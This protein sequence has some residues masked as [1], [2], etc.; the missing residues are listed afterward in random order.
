VHISRKAATIASGACLA[1]IIA[2]T[3]NQ[4]LAHAWG[5][6]VLGSAAAAGAT[7]L[8]ARRIIRSHPDFAQLDDE[9]HRRLVRWIGVG[10]AAHVAWIALY[11]INPDLALVWL[12]A[13]AG[14][15]LVEYVGARG[16]EYLMAHPVRQNLPAIHE[17]EIVTESISTADDP[18]ADEAVKS[19]AS[20]LA[21]AGYPILQVLE[22][23]TFRDGVGRRFT[24]RKPSLAAVAETK[25][26]KSNAATDFGVA[27]AEN[28]AIALSEATGRKI[29]TDWV[30][31]TKQDYAGYYTISVVT[32]DVMAEVV[33]YRFD[34]T[35]R[36]IRELVFVGIQ[37]DGEEKYLDVRQHGQIV[38]KTRE[39]KTSLVHVLLTAMFQSV[40]AVV[41]VCGVLKLYD[42]LA[43][44]LAGY[45]GEDVEIPFD[46]IASGQLHTM[47]MLVGA[48]A[49]A[50]YRQALP[51]DERGGLPSLFVFLDEAPHVLRN[52]SI[53]VEWQGVEYTAAQLVALIG[54][55]TGS[56]DVWEVVIAQRGTNDM[57]G[58]EGGDTKANFGYS[59]VFKSKDK[60][61]LGRTLGDE[62]YKLPMPRHKGENWMD[63]G[64]GDG[65]THLR[66]PYI[67]EVD[68]SKPR[69]HDGMT[70]VDIAR[71]LFGS[72]TRLDPGTENAVAEAIGDVFRN[73]HRYA[74]QGLADYLNGAPTPQESTATTRGR[75]DARAALEA[76]FGSPAELLASAPAPAVRAVPEPTDRRDLVLAILGQVVE[77]TFGESGTVA[78]GDIIKALREMGDDAPNEN[79]VTNLLGK[80]VREGV[81]ERPVKGRYCLPRRHVA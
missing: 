60:A 56:A 51:L 45:E 15:G 44:W 64:D 63:A 21:A 30:T 27:S 42:M 80:L 1:L 3:G 76:M 41:W 77:G 32:Q 70:L 10:A 33:P 69:L 62:H 81:I 59:A 12:A 49:A 36:S 24:V 38:G 34:P 58:D 22:T 7:T 6:I 19:M 61:E 53:K 17:A 31:I 29:M 68:P 18:H 52:R 2:A 71:A 11:L 67:Q 8:A 54:Q 66:T 65:P 79:A 23:S 43:G 25:K 72:K 55:T 26:A 37:F 14:L 5:W 48:L 75:A 39:G 28:V 9:N 78:T 35:P 50:R 40:D 20:V 4:W 74:T 47:L 57:L 73:R 13:L 46:W 16:L